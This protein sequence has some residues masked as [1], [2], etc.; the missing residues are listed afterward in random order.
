MKVLGAA[1]LLLTTV[2]VAIAAAPPDPSLPAPPAFFTVGVSRIST[3]EGDSFHLTLEGGKVV[4]VRLADADCH[5]L[6]L[7][8]RDS[9]KAVASGILETQPVWIFPLGHNVTPATDELWAEVWTPKGWMGEVLVKAGYAVSR[10]GLDAGSLVPFGVGAAAGTGSPPSAPAFLCTSCTTADG[11]VY[12]MEGAGHR[13][14]GRLADVAVDPSQGGAAKDV[15]TRLLGAGPVWVFPSN[16]GRVGPGGEFRVRLWTREGWLSEALIKAGAAK[17]GTPDDKMP[18]AA[19][20][21]GSAP[22][23]AAP[24]TGATGSAP[25][26]GSFGGM[27]W[28]P[29]AISKSK[30]GTFEWQSANF[31]VSQPTIRLSWN[32]KPV[33]RAF[34]VAVSL[35]RLD[36]EQGPGGGSSTNACAFAGPAGSQILHVR[37]GDYWIHVAG[38]IETNVTVEELFGPS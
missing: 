11:I 38:S 2:A 26:S 4:T 34:S 23:P 8:A 27:S 28:R 3:I 33:R 7:R 20:P 12:E 9:A 30:G 15:A 21:T 14:R 10:S 18:A 6:D 5:G 36:D 17:R 13:L 24:A 35:M 37:P 31:K 25:K 32:L 1:G 19:Q 29:I 16:A 22:T